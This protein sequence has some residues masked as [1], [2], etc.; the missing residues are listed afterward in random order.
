MARLRWKAASIITGSP[1]IGGG[2]AWAL[3]TSAGVL[4]G[5]NLQSGA[6]RDSLS[7]GP[8]VRLPRR[9]CRRRR[10]V[11]TNHGITAVGGI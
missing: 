1:V 11:P 4:D 3:D 5:L 9:R 10:F 7:I 8:V 6:R 2:F